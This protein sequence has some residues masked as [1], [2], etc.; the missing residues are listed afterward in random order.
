[1]S[2]STWYPKT[3]TPAFSAEVPTCRLTSS[4]SGRSWIKCQGI[5]VSAPPLNCVVMRLIPLIVLF[6]RAFFEPLGRTRRLYSV[7]HAGE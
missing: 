3:R 2:S 6:H 1:M 7:V 5:K 4:C